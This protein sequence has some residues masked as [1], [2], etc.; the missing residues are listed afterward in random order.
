ML[1][2]GG[3][4]VVKVKVA[5]Q[6]NDRKLGAM[7]KGLAFEIGNRGAVKGTS[8]TQML[9]RGHLEF[10]FDSDKKADEFREALTTYLPA[11]F[12]HVVE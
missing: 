12:A 5:I 7:V 6:T 11:K 8:W 2:V 3:N 9:L 4:I 10:N 1:G